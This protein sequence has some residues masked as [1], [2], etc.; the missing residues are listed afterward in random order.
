VSR[1][2]FFNYFSS[3]SDVL[4]GAL[5][6]RLARFAHALR[7]DTAPELDVAVRAAVRTL[8]DGFAPDALALAWAQADAMGLGDEFVREA[9]VRRARVAQAVAERLRRGGVDALRAEVVGAAYGGAVLAAIA[10]W[11][12]A[13]AGRVPLSDVLDAALVAV[14]GAAAPAGVRQLR[15]VVRTSDLDA[16]L[17]LYR[18]TAG[19]AE[20]AAFSGDGDARVVILDAGQA[21]LELA[22]PAQVD[23]IDA[24]ETDGRTPSDRIRVALEV[25]D[26]TAVTE[27]L[28]AAGAR[29]EAAPRVT[30]W[31]SRNSRLR[32]PDDLQLTLFEEGAG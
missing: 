31:G 16:A 4:W 3:K 32:G 27:R 1:S 28:T 18:D 12:L 8:L 29:L 20:R 19:M 22:N 24:V 2:S 6:D 10:Q 21:T 14:P 30:P 15:V 7:A 9:G 25:A 26:A 5:D 23:F 17:A 11:A 13:G